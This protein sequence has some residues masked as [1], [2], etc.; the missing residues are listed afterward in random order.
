MK[1]VPELAIGTLVVV[2]LA[3]CDAPTAPRPDPRS[4]PARSS[5]CGNM[6]R[7]VL[8]TRVGTWPG[9]FESHSA[10]ITPS[11]ARPS[12]GFDPGDECMSA[13][14]YGEYSQWLEA[15]DMP[16]SPEM[17]VW[18]G[19]DIQW[20]DEGTGAPCPA[21]IS[22]VRFVEHVLET[23]DDAVFTIR[24]NPGEEIVKVA[25]LGTD[26]FGFSMAKYRLP[27]NIYNSRDGR[28]SLYG[29]YISVT[30]FFKTFGIGGISFRLDLKLIFA[31]NYEGLYGQ[32]NPVRRNVSSIMGGSDAGWAFEESSGWSNGFGDGWQAA[33]ENYIATGSCTPGWVIFVD[34][35]QKCDV[36]GH[37][38]NQ[39]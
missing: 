31:W 4:P 12:F 28:F 30:C 3:G 9:G 23:G 15:Y 1:T 17:D 5:S 13:E 35:V 32:G 24:A 11:S 16:P 25:E 6:E 18:Y 26:A 10:A 33:L 34:G 20:P 14:T 8:A 19:E 39:T 22:G 37:P 36:N 21:T 38:V 7:P 29:G 27:E 2:V